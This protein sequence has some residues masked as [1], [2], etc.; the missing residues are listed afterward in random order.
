MLDFVAP[1]MKRSGGAET[2][3]TRATVQYTVC[4]V[5]NACFAQV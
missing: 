4:I 2:L 3:I 1:K 5:N